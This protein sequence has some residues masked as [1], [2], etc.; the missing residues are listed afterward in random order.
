MYMLAL[1]FKQRARKKRRD[2]KAR[3][4]SGGMNIRL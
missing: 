2:K 1:V 4:T 3:V